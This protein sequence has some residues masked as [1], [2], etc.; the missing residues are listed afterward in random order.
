LAVGSRN[1]FGCRLFGQHSGLILGTSLLDWS[2]GRFEEDLLGCS[3]FEL[4]PGCCSCLGCSGCLDCFQGAPE[5]VLRKE[6]TL[7]GLCWEAFLCRASDRLVACLAEG[8]LR[9]GCSQE[10]ICL[11]VLPARQGLLAHQGLSCEEASC[12]AAP[13]E[14]TCA[15]ER[16]RPSEAAPEIVACLVAE[17]LAVGS[18]LAQ[19]ASRRTWI[20]SSAL[21]G[22]SCRS[23]LLRRR[24]LPFPARWH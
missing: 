13:L 21:S 15:E 9:T 16:C 18:L 11:E 17:G 19:G 12:L 3:S 20:G 14:G 1:R 22:C 4:N 24:L 6:D 23:W 10:G 2:R 5:P 8:S 7:E